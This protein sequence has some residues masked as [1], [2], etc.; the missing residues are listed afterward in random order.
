MNLRE[1]VRGGME[2]TD[3]AQDRDQWRD[4]VNM[5][6]NLLVPSDKFLRAAQL[7]VSREGLSPMEL[8]ERKFLS[9][10]NIRFC[11]CLPQKH[12]LKLQ[13]KYHQYFVIHKTITL[14]GYTCSSAFQTER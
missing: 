1:I 9:A 13:N 10:L 14:K 3:L 2:W 5:V 11:S 4:L 12:Y 6:I 7:A 8:L